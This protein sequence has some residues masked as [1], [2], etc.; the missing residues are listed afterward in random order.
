MK[1]PIRVRLTVIYSVIL[2]VVVAAMELAGYLSV[3]AAIHSIVDHELETRR[4]GIEDHLVRHLDKFTWPEMD[5]AL[6]AHPAFQPA[7]LI[8]HSAEGESIYEGRGMH[9]V[10]LPHAGGI[11][12]VNATS[13]TLRVLFT[14]RQIVGRTYDL[15]MGTDLGIAS[16]ILD[17]MW[18]IMLVS[19]PAVLAICAATGY[20]MSGRA[21]SPIQRIVSAARAIDSRRL[22]QR[23]P[24]PDTGDEVQQLAETFNGMLDRIESGFRQMREFTANASHELRTPVAIIRAASEVALLRR[25]SSETLYRETLERILR[26]SERNT[27]L[28]ESMLEISRIDSGVDRMERDPV[29]LNQSVSEACERVAPLASARGL[30]LHFEPSMQPINVLASPEQLRRLWLILLDNAVKYTAA[31]GTIT[32]RVTDSE[33][34]LVEI[35]DSGIGIAA[36][37][38]PLIFDRFYRTDKARSRSEGGAGLGLAIAREITVLH[39]AEI[40]VEST[41]GKGSRFYVTFLRQ[42]LPPADS[43]PRDEVLR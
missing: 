12:T 36:E 4:A 17:R 40:N 1:L 20:W 38:L 19:L 22:S 6:D 26:E 21:L 23:V 31:E 13:G 7:Y 28:L 42:I 5:A 11:A 2:V 39:D 27:T 37:H 8:I 32:A 3:S 24:V 16:A 30:T 43:F 15:A 14:R 9:G 34:P 10:R 25:R 29:S 35:T 33:S 41:P 18:L